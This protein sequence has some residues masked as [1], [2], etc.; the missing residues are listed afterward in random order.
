[1]L[2]TG[3]CSVF[4]SNTALHTMPWTSSTDTTHSA[5]SCKCLTP[6]YSFLKCEALI[7][8]HRYAVDIQNFH[9]VQNFEDIEAAESFFGGIIRNLRRSIDAREN[10]AQEARARALTS[11]SLFE[12][13]VEHWEDVRDAYPLEEFHADP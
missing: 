11:N 7:P 8:L 2:L 9:T 12:G 13:S 1:M 4:S 3:G 5:R 6:A 10:R